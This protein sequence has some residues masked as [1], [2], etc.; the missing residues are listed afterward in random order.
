MYHSPWL[1]SL[2]LSLQSRTLSASRLIFTTRTI[3]VFTLN[4][5]NQPFF[6]PPVFVLQPHRLGPIT[7]KFLDFC[8]GFLRDLRRF[9]LIMHKAHF[10]PVCHCKFGKKKGEGQKSWADVCGAFLIITFDHQTVGVGDGLNWNT[11]VR[12]M[13]GILCLGGDM[14]DST[15]SDMQGSFSKY[16]HPSNQYQ[17]G[18]C[19]IQK[20]QR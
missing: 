19:E 7:G 6:S 20:I 12:N 15:F 16:G 11:I 1:S 3:S 5:P 13:I 18:L 14:F 2:V 9:R 10:L 8:S 17:Y 4:R